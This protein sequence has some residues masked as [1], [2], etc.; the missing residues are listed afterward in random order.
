[1]LPLRNA[2][3]W[4]A[5]SVVILLLVLVAALS[6]AFWFF[7]DR[8][9]ALFWFQNSDK[10]LHAFTF[11]ALS[12]WFAGLFERRAW[13]RIAIGLMSFGFLVELFQLQ[14]SYRTADWLDIAANTAGII[15]GLIIAT[16]GLGGWALRFE[17]WNSR[18]NQV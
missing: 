4:Q 11:T 1:M 18:R 2:G 7:D 15:I 13:W 16:T 10:W 6:P 9:T 17:D 8:S 14:V 5:L 3:L 12:I